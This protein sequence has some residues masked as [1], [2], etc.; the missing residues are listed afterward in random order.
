MYCSHCGMKNNESAQYCI[1]DGASLV[2]VIEKVKVTQENHKYCMECSHE[3]ALNAIYCQQCGHSVEKVT[4]KEDGI[5]SGTIPVH[6]EDHVNYEKEDFISS[7]LN[8]HNL[9]RIAIFNAFSIIALF[10]F[11]LIVSSSA[12][13][14]LLESL[15]SE[16]GSLV[17]SL[18]VVS[19]TDVFMISHMASLHYRANALMFEGV[20]ETTSGLFLLLFIPAIIFILI[21]FFMNKRVTKSSIVERLSICLSFSIM[22]GI[23]VGLISTF[24]GV[25]VDIADP[26]GFIGNITISSD[27]SFFES[28]FNALIISFI[29]TSVG[30]MIGVAKEQRF[31]NKQYG[32]SISRAILHSVIGLVFM[33]LIGTV[34][35]STNDELTTGDETGDVLLGSQ[36]GGYLWNISQFGTLNFETTSYGE[37]ITASYSLMGGPKA[38]ED[39]EE[40]EELFLE[41]KWLWI[42]V[43]IPI[44]L[45]FLAGNKLRKSTQGNILYELGVYA[46]VFGLINALF[47]SI[48]RLTIDTN[49][50]DVF[51]ATFGFSTFG[52]FI[53]SAIFAFIV[54]Y[55]AVMLTN[56]QVNSNINQSM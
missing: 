19:A 24:A 40:F 47:V 4:E 22:Y 18:K 9:K 56:R 46:I 20:L 1:N 29:F 39:E 43:L 51:N 14:L 35:F 42:L 2:P 25:S 52:T 8:K 37:E 53:V 26:T 5:T 11:S 15:R 50:D 23:I 55:V 36:I 33:I 13:R 49:F 10:V 7:I 6:S 32:V 48:S 3:N 17:D 27:Y 54:S 21:G 28:I 41:L 31:N 45:H 12:N 44:G 38:S 16:F 34:F 30:A